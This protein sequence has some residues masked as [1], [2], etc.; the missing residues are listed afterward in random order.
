VGTGLL[1][2]ALG[3]LW[4]FPD[5][6]SRVRALFTQTTVAGEDCVLEDA[7]CS[8]VL[9]DGATVRLELGPRPLRAGLPLKWSVEVTDG[10][11]VEGIEIAGLSMNMGLTRVPLQADGAGRWSARASLPVCSSAAMDWRADVLLGGTPPRVVSVPF[12]TS[13][14]VLP[15]QAAEE[16]EPAVSTHGELRVET[17]EGALALSDLRGKAVLVY[18]GYTSCPDI[19]PT[20]LST[21]SA[22]IGQLPEARQADVAGLFISVDPGRD[23]VAHIA[24][25]TRFFHPAI[26]G[27]TADEAA[28]R[29]MAADWGVTWRRADMPGSAMGYAIDHSTDA[30]LVGPDGR[31]LGPVP[32]GIAPDALATR[33]LDAIDP[34]APPR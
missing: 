19:C 34:G 30:H 21:I 7:P 11:P 25:Y 5:A 32:H 17:A 2:V 15:H 33:I 18:F 26:K 8:V 9:D 29:A 10:V 16:V 13:G 27:G 31:Y 22:A 23:T 28:L 6:V 24:E 12:S 4:A 3:L 20:T 1:A 14:R